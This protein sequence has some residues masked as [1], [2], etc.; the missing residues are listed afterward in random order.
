MGCIPV[1]WK[2]DDR[3]GHVTHTA[4]EYLLGQVEGGV[5]CPLTMTY[6]VVPALKN[7]SEL[8]SV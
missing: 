4:L 1:A 2:T 5:C 7:N 6:A 8:M 3:G